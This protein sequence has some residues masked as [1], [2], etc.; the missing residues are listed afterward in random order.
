MVEI[1]QLQ[2][3]RTNIVQ[4]T[5]IRVNELI[6]EMY[7]DQDRLSAISATMSEID[8]R[9]CRHCLIHALYEGEQLPTRTYTNLALHLVKSNAIHDLSLIH[10]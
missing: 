2:Q 10:I 5:A 1:D 6:T 3:E 9:I 4:A 7:P 8:P